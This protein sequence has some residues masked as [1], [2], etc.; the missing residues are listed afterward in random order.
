MNS[1]KMLPSLLIFAKVANTGSF[2]QAARL[3]GMSKSAVSQ[4]VSRLEDRLGSQL[5]RRN[6][7]GL[8]VTS[9]GNRLLQRCELLQD[10]VDL[11][12]VEMSNAEK[13]PAGTL[14]VTFPHSLEHDVAVPAVRQLCQEY[15]G[16]EPR[17][18]VTDEK[19]DL[20]RNKLDVAIFGGKPDDS[21]YRALPIGTMTEIWC[22]SSEYLQRFGEPETLGDL[23]QHQWIGTPWQKNPLSVYQ[24]SGNSA[25][26]RIKMKSYARANTL[27][28]SIELAKQH[29]GLILIPDIVG[30]PLI[31]EN[32]LVRIL[33]R[34]RG[35]EWPF[36][37]IH[38]FQ[39]EKPVYIT[40]FHQ[41]VA[42]YFAKAQV[43]T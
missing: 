5:L 19:L 41:L 24:V 40:R 20:V 27:P 29:M 8:S 15:P 43:T 25:P 37:F 14:S 23:Q 9:L 33:K 28:C 10:Q 38:P 16:L 31:H 17:L 32:S 13:T 2:T 34:L 42:H 22:A 26:E 11:A 39:A 18:V 1:I 36:Y 6:T 4:Q 35:P 3:L 30:Q 7:R 21:S 12:M